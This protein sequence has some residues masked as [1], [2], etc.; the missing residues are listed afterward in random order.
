MSA[1]SAPVTESPS[2]T[3][4]RSRPLVLDVPDDPVPEVLLPLEPVPPVDPE[5]VEPFEGARLRPRSVP[6]LA[7]PLVEP[8]GAVAAGPGESEPRPLSTTPAVTAAA[9]RTTTP[10]TMPT[11]FGVFGRGSGGGGPG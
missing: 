8:A 1:A 5:P 11:I 10:T 3:V 9:T 4:V 6:P 2:V 7:V